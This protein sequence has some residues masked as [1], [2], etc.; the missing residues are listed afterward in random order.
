VIRYLID[1]DCSIYAML[2]TYPGLG[3]RLAECEPGEVGLSAIC[4][5]EIQVGN[6]LGHP[7]DAA[8]I[9]AF[10]RAIPIVPFDERAARTYGSMP[11]KRARFDRLLAAHALSIGA[12]VVSSN[13]ADFADVPGLVV[14]NWTV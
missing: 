13:E 6:S 4:Y 11:F 7:P 8:V 12:V 9:D 3:Q 10:V 5:V 1:T 2:G 14:E